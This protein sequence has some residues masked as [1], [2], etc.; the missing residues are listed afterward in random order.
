MNIFSNHFLQCTFSILF[1]TFF[2]KVSLKDFIYITKTME[3]QNNYLDK[4]GFQATS[5]LNNMKNN[6]NRTEIKW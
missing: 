3:Y 6:K 2:F 4:L 1:G 5:G